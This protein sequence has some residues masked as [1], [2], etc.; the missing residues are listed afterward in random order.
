M[1][2]LMSII[3]VLMNGFSHHETSP[4]SR[5]H[6]WTLSSRQG[7]KVGGVQMEG[8]HQW[9]VDQ[10]DSKT[11]AHNCPS[12]TARN[13]VFSQCVSNQTFMSSH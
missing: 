8:G 1:A 5:L 13:T 4:S 3:H 10:R 12:A 6:A 7:V 9:Y 2:V 11:S